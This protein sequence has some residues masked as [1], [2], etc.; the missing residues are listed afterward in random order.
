M[1]EETSAEE[2]ETA[3]GNEWLLHTS[4]RGQILAKGWNVLTR[5]TGD[6]ADT[7]NPNIT[8]SIDSEHSLSLGSSSK[9][10]V[11]LQHGSYRELPI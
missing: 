8:D 3:K 2:E 9:A 4:K 6:I 10:E 7:K 11:E 5:K 1:K